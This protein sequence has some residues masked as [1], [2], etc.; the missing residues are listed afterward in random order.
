MLNDIKN[1]V[2]NRFC[3]DGKVDKIV[4]D[5]G[6]QYLPYAQIAE[7]KQ[8]HSHNHIHFRC[9]DCDK[10]E[11]LEGEKPIS[12]PEGY[13]AKIHNRFISGF[14]DDCSPNIVD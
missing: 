6:K 2:P 10:V 11:C 5:D 14:Y 4:R 12:L 8:V 9:L 7:K 3:E 13:I 1:L